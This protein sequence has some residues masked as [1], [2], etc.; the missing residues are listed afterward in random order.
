MDYDEATEKKLSHIVGQ[1]E[2]FE[3]YPGRDTAV[4]VITDDGDEFVVINR[5]AV[6]RLLQYAGEE[7]NVELQGTVV[8]DHSLG[9]NVL[10]VTSIKDDGEMEA[11]ALR[12]E[13]KILQAERPKKKKKRLVSVV[14][15]ELSQDDLL[16]MLEGFDDIVVQEGENELEE[17]PLLDDDDDLALDLIDQDLDLDLELEEDLELIDELDKLLKKNLD[18][19]KNHKKTPREK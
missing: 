15:E 9:M 14:D 7:I 5:K 6:K 11:E 2:V 8:F 4:S 10:N 3:D 19:G 13:E 1:I 16:M 12:M 17:L 18:A